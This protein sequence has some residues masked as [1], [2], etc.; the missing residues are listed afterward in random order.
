VKNAYSF[1][2]IFGICR[3]KKYTGKFT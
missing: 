2:L 1:G 3:L